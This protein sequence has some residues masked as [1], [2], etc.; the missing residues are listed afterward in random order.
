[1]LVRL[2][3]ARLDTKNFDITAPEYNGVTLPNGKQLKKAYRCP[4]PNDDLC[5]ASDQGEGYGTTTTCTVVSDCE[6]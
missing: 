1:M 3:S 4:I 6:Q 5:V 2:G